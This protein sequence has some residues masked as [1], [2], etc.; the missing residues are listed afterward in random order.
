MLGRLGQVC[1]VLGD[2]ARAKACYVLAL[3]LLRET[4]YWR[5]EVFELAYASLLY[6]HLGDHHTAR[7]YSEQALTIA[8]NL[9]DCDLCGLALTRMGHALA[10]LG[11]PKAAEDVYR[12]ALDTRQELNARRP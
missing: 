6:H 9:G 2:Y 8:L 10:G 7:E 11:E 4:S 12:Q 3:S 1:N 5:A